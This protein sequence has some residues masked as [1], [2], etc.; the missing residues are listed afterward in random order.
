ML[1]AVEYYK[2]DEEKPYN[3]VT[4]TKSDGTRFDYIPFIFCGSVNNSPDV[5]DMPL[6]LL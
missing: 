5:D 2:D 4:P 1:Y 6:W 3:I